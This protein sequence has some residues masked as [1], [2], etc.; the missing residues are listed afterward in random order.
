MPRRLAAVVVALAVALALGLTACSSDKK[1]VETA[2]ADTS[3]ASDTTSPEDV[4]VPDAQVTAG[5][6]K[7]GDQIALALTQLT[8][9]QDQAK[10]TVEAAH[11]TWYSFEGTVK[12]NSQDLHLDMEDGLGAVKNGV[13][14]NDAARAQRGSTD[15]S[16]AASKYLQEWPGTGGSTTTKAP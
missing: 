8:S 16:A 6:A 9:D 7:V 1:E 10:A 12:Q 3:A 15:F 11:Q 5:L 4:I 2:P 13:D 14:E